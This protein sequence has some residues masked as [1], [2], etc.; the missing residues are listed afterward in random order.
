VSELI[1]A[2]GSN[3]CSGRFQDYGV[4]PERPGEPAM[5]SGYRLRFNKR[6]ID[7]SGKA[8]V[9]PLAESDIWGVLYSIPGSQLPTLD[10]GEGPGYARGLVAVRT[11]ARDIE[12]WVYEAKNPSADPDLRPYQWYKRFLV[13]GAKEHGLPSAYIDALQDI[14]AVDDPD[15]ARDARKRLLVCGA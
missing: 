8:N 11:P 7:G 4:V 13:E 10:T 2:F 1:F 12:A 6:S 5:L 14:A 3:M 15:P 9:E